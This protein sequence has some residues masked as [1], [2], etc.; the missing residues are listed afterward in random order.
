MSTPAVAAATELDASSLDTSD[1]LRTP[2]TETSPD[3][4]PTLVPEATP[5]ADGQY[6]YRDAVTFYEG[7]D[8]I[9]CSGAVIAPRFILTTATCVSQHPKIT[10][11][12]TFDPKSGRDE[13]RL[14]G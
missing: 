5:A 1:L 3:P 13:K 11:I 14:I 7:F 8:K 9:Y 6:V 4:A 10:A 12:S 2:F